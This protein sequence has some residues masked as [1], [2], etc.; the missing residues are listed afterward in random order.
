MIKHA[1]LLTSPPLCVCDVPRADLGHKASALSSNAL[2]LTGGLAGA[3]VLYLVARKLTQG[4][5]GGGGDGEQN[6]AQEGGAAASTTAPAAASQQQQGG[7]GVLVGLD[8]PLVARAGAAEE[9]AAEHTMVGSHV[10]GGAGPG[11]APAA[12][13]GADR[14]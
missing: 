3:V 8:D 9:R 4:P 2:G 11:G 10:G 13:S 12:S 1:R 5:S 7:R 6:G 14:A